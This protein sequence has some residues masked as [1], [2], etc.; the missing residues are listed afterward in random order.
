MQTQCK[1]SSKYM[2]PFPPDA[3]F[4]DCLRP[5]STEDGVELY[6]IYFGVPEMCGVWGAS[7]DGLEVT[8]RMD[9]GGF[10][11]FSYQPRYARSLRW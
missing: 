11:F 5:I 6:R 2:F 1:S 4:R 8:R 7:S 10:L 9:F 3:K